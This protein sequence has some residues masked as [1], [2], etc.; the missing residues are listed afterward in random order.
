M[1]EK[2]GRENFE[3][4]LSYGSLKSLI[5]VYGESFD[6][7]YISFLRIQRKFGFTRR[8]SYDVQVTYTDLDD[9]LP[10]E[11]VTDYNEF[12]VRILRTP[13]V[14]RTVFN[15]P[16]PTFEWLCKAAS[17][18][19]SWT[20]LSTLIYQNTDEIPSVIS[21]G[22]RIEILTRLYHPA[23]YHPQYERLL[24]ELFTVMF[25]DTR[26]KE[27]YWDSLEDL[28]RFDEHILRNQQ[29]FQELLKR[30]GSPPL[31][32]LMFFNEIKGSILS[33]EPK[34]CVVL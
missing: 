33:I 10:E 29:T 1:S 9:F 8:L 25:L 2:L 19:L 30:G 12:L 14:P 31:P 28:E 21:W 7:N 17:K 27:Y 23:E 26:R 13:K 22:S 4:V 34:R 24:D 20:L 15:G 3:T 5:E 18:D 32:I 16:H 6:L 11:G